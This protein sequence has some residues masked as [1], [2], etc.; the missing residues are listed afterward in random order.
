VHGED[1]VVDLGRQ[2]LL[3]RTGQL[4][5]DEERFDAADQEEGEGGDAVHDADLLVIDRRDPAAPAGARRRAS[6]DAEGLEVVGHPARGEGE[7]AVFGE[8][9]GLPQSSVWR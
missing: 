4:R 1:L 2:Q 3:A 7:R 8:G 5:A 9:H 6:E